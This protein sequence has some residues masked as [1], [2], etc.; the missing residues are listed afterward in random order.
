MNCLEIHSFN[1]SVR[2][3]SRKKKYVLFYYK[4]VKFEDISISQRKISFLL[5]IT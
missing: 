4:I 5:I 3:K 2:H 1:V